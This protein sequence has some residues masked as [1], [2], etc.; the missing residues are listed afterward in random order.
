MDPRQ[1]GQQYP[2]SIAQGVP[3]YPPNGS[4]T[5]TFNTFVNADDGSGFDPSWNNQLFTN[6]QQPND[7]FDPGAQA[8]QQ[9][10]YQNPGLLPMPDYGIQPRGY[11]QTYARSPAPFNFSGYTSNA[12]H[13]FPQSVYE[14]T[15]AYGDLP[16]SDRFDY[17]GENHLGR[18]NPNQTISPQALQTYSTFPQN[19]LANS[20]QVRL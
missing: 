5:D 7:G 12:S 18:P 3:S 1:Q 16:L 20:N 19:S 9:D 4:Q 10:A 11:D 17:T 15:F 14:N 6:Q 8:W 2:G 13:A